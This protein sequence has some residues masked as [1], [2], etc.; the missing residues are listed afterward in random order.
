LENDDINLAIGTTMR[1]RCRELGF[2]YIFKASFDKA[3]RTSATSSRGPGLSHGL[4]QLATIKEALGVPV[5][6]DIHDVDQ[7]APAAEIVDLLQIP[8][9]LCRQTDLIEACA[10]TGRPINL[11]KGQ[12][13]S[14]AEMEHV[15]EKARAAGAQQMMATERGTFFGYNRLVNDFVGLGDMMALGVPVC[16]DV[17]HST[18]LPG[19]GTGQTAG[20][21]DRA[22]ILA[23]A[24]VAAG[25]QALFMECHPS[26]IS[27]R[28][29][30]S[31]M[32]TL[33]AACEILETAKRLRDAIF[34]DFIPTSS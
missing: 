33:E 24:A 5:T 11:K 21:P 9:F 22:D 4:S 32:Q 31:T 10:K 30:A 27:G 2:G 13:L 25:V 1:D 18:Q 6:T 23:R 34:G 16:F 29:D 20:R 14:P 17:T 8:A 12:F 28:S 26:P 7:A 3:N 19:G 15:L